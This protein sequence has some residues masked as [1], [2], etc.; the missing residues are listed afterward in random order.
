[1]VHSPPS[2]SLGT[3]RSDD[4]VKS[5]HI[6]VLFRRIFPRRFWNVSDILRVDLCPELWSIAIT[7]CFSSPRGCMYSRSTGLYSP[8][9]HE[10]WDKARGFVT[11]G[12]LGR[13][14]FK[15]GHLVAAL[16]ASIRL[17]GFIRAPSV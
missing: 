17:S 10:S 2:T 9:K 16:C 8:P 1:V 4:D 6:V 5:C 3:S 7:K 13:A 14:L 12:C 15:G 11:Y